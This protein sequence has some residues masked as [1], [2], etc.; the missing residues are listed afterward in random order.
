[1]AD[2]DEEH[3]GGGVQDPEGPVD[4]EGVQSRD[5]GRDA[6]RQDHLEDV[7]GPDVGLGPLDGGRVR[8]RAEVGPGLELEVRDGGL[9]RA[10]SLQAGDHGLDP[11]PGIAI[12]R[13]GAP[14]VVE[15]GVGHHP[16]GV[17]EVIEHHHGVHEGQSEDR[18]PEIVG[19]AVGEPLPEPHG[20]VAEVAEEAADEGGE[21]G[22]SVRP[23]AVQ[24][25]AHHL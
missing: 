23:V 19:G 14:R 24:V 22:V 8:L 2:V 17:P 9:D 21:L 25:L 12:G 10:R 3:V 16:Q 6:A 20:V 7:A 11:G 5:R 13:L 15:D 18:E 4:G 1:V